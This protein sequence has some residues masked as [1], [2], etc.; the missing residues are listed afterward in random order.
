MVVHSFWYITHDG[1]KALLADYFM[2]KYVLQV[3]TN[4]GPF[5]QQIKHHKMVKLLIE[6]V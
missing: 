3:N 5:V 1:I 6:I 2:A 4:F